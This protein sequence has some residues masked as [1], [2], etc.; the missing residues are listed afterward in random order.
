[1]IVISYNEKG[2]N[3]QYQQK[4]INNP[5]IRLDNFECF[6]NSMSKQPTS[7]QIL[8]NKRGMEP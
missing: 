6:V 4:S 1:M 3:T 7:W 5:H 8:E 2:K